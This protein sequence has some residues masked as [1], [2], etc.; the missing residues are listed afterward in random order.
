MN[1]SVP[2]NIRMHSSVYTAGEVVVVED[3]TRLREPSDRGWLPLQTDGELNG[4]T[5]Q[6]QHRALDRL[7]TQAYSPPLCHSCS[8]SRALS[9]SLCASESLHA[10]EMDASMINAAGRGQEN[11]IRARV[12]LEA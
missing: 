8:D 11:D 9:L 5:S 12:A 6:M 1:G 4:L 7:Q 10:V 3:E 2:V